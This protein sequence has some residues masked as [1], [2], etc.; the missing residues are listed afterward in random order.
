MPFPAFFLLAGAL[1]AFEGIS[2]RREKGQLLDLEAERQATINSISVGVETM[3]ASNMFD[4]RQ[5]EAMQKQEQT[6]QALM[7]STDPA[8]QRAGATMMQSIATAVRANIQQNET[9]ARADVEMRKDAEIAAAG[10]GLAANEKRTE[11]GIT[12][13]EQLAQELKAFDDT[14]R[15]YAKVMNL[16]DN[17]DQLSSLAG[18]TAFVQAIDNSVVREGELLKYQG[19]NGI[20]TQIVN[21]VNKSAG[22]DFEE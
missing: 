14:T 4:A 9:E 19:A 18:L 6:A 21:L 12:M 8:Q 22:A 5:I 7:R 16:L 15:S 2:R 11:R 20:I 10:L 13:S 3:G 1:G 17:N